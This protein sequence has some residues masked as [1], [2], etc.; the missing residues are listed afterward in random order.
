M[1]DSKENGDDSGNDEQ[2]TGMYDSKQNGDD[3]GNDEQQTGMYNSNIG[4]AIRIRNPP[5]F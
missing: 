4:L 2:Q 1:Y 5:I 3:S